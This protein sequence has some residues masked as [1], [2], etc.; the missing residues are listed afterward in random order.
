MISIVNKQDCC[1]CAACVQVCPKNCI[2]LFT[3]N[4]GFLYPKTDANVCVECGLCEKVCPILNQ[5]GE[6][7]PVKVIAAINPDDEVRRNSS[8]GG[9]FSILAEN[10]IRQGGVV[11]GARFDE[12]WQVVISS[13]E[14]I[15]QLS[16]F[17]GSKYLQ[18]RVENS[19][20]QCKDFLNKGRKVLFS[21]TPCQIA[22]LLNYLRKPYDNLITV[23]FVCH[24]VPSPGVWKKY[25]DE[26]TEA[27][28][29][30]VEDVKFRTKPEGWKKFH[31]GITLDKEGASY[32]LSSRYSDNTYMKAFLSNMILRPSCYACPAKSGKSQS[33]LTIAD[34]W[35]VE[36]VMP[37]MDDDKG[38]SIIL[39]NTPKFES[40]TDEEKMKCKEV[41]YDTIILFNPSITS[42][43]TP[44]RQRKRFFARWDNAVSI[45]SLMEQCMR[46]SLL[47][48]LYAYRN[49]V[50]LIQSLIGGGKNE[51][52]QQ[53]LETMNGKFQVREISFRRKTNGWH[54][55]QILIRIE[56]KQER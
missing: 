18:A 13:V 36:K 27:S 8:S 40:I 34:F 39:I 44:H 48:R 5:K 22:G 50:V 56:S 53:D 49:P 37:D 17:R 14:S 10:V 3:D 16:A 4:E 33:D 11:F 21:G 28:K 54:N 45:S 20:A 55:Y 29:V 41:D 1:G 42:S 30:A 12:N 51:P 19:Y 31:L 47:Q 25:L 24:G 43:S 2:E 23:D 35:G 7:K 26:V 46:P 52:I 38:T 9:V 15:E 32:I 6:R